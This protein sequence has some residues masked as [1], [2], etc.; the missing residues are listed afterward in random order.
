MVVVVVVVGLGGDGL[1]LRLSP[2]AT[3]ELDAVDVVSCA[4]AVVSLGPLGFEELVSE[5]VS[6]SMRSQGVQRRK[7]RTRK[8]GKECRIISEANSVFLC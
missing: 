1:R 7:V 6:E 8:R 4:V 3:E 2:C 5:L